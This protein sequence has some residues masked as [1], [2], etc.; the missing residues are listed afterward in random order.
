[1]S[2]PD[3]TYK[4]NGESL[5][6]Q[7]F[8]AK[9]A[10]SPEL[11]EQF[12]R[13][14]G[15]QPLLTPQ[16]QPV[17]LASEPTRALSSPLL[18]AIQNAA[19]ASPT[20]SSDEAFSPK[21]ASRDG[22][23]VT[24]ALNQARAAMA[25]PV[26]RALDGK[27]Q[28]PDFRQD[29][30]D[31][32]SS[33]LDAH[34]GA[35]V[36]IEEAARRVDNRLYNFGMTHSQQIL[37]K[38]MAAKRMQNGWEAITK[39][40]A[41][42]TAD[43]GQ[44]LLSQHYLAESH[45]LM[46]DVSE[47]LTQSAKVT[48]LG[49]VLAKLFNPKALVPIGYKWP[50]TRKQVTAINADAT[51]RSIVKAMD[52]AKDAAVDSTEKRAKGLLRKAAAIVAKKTGADASEVERIINAMG[53]PDISVTEQIEHE[54]VERQIR[55]VL[56]ALDPS[57]DVTP[58]LDT[59]YEQVN[60]QVSEILDKKT[61]PV[62]P[63][64]APK[65]L[66]AD[67]IEA[68][69]ADL[70]QTK[71]MAQAAFDATVDVLRAANPDLAAALEGQ[72][73]DFKIE[74]TSEVKRLSKQLAAIR[75]T[76]AAASTPVTEQVKAAV[77]TSEVK[78]AMKALEKT[79]TPKAALDVLYNDVRRQ[80]AA[81]LNRWLADIGPK[82]GPQSAD[83]RVLA[84]KF[85][86]IW[87][88]SQLAEDAFKRA[89][90]AL[91]VQHPEMKAALS[92]AVFDPN[93]NPESRKIVRQM[94]DF[95]KEIYQTLR[96][97]HATR[98][99]LRAIVRTGMSKIVD[100]T[101][102]DSVA[103]A[104]VSVYDEELV[105]HTN[106]ALRSLATNNQA[107]KEKLDTPTIDKLTKAANLGALAEEQFYNILAPRFGLPAWD[108]DMADKIDLSLEEVQRL[109]E[110]SIQR[111][112]QSMKIMSEI[113]K[114]HRQSAV[115]LERFSHTA[116]VLSMFWTA[117]LLS[118]PVTHIVNGASTAA[119]ILLENMV[120]ATG[121]YWANKSKVGNAEA[122][123]Y[124]GDFGRALANVF[125]GR[126]GAALNSKVGIDMRAALTAGVTRFKSDKG[127][128]MSPLEGW[129]YKTDPKSLNDVF[130]NWLSMYKYVG[131]AMLMA[132]SANS[133]IAA[134]SNLLMRARFEAQESGL[135]GQALEDRLSEVL[136]NSGNAYAEAKKQAQEEYDRGDF[137]QVLPL[138]NGAKPIPA[139][140]M[141]A[142]RI[143]QL[144]EEKLFKADDIQAARD[145]AARATFNADNTGLIGMVADQIG[146]IN[147]KLG[148]TKVIFPFVRTLANLTNNA[149]DY[150]PYG[151]AR[152][153]NF[154][155]AG[156]LASRFHPDSL[157]GREYL[158][159]VPDRIDPSSPEYYAQMTR[160]AAGTATF[161]LLLG[162]AMKGLDDEKDG[163]RAFFEITTS[164]PA[165]FAQRKVLQSSGWLPNSVRI[166]DTRF[167]W[168]DWPA[169]NMV[170][171][172]L[173][174]YSD[175]RRY[176]KLGDKEAGEQLVVAAL[177]V[178]SSIM[179]RSMFT[180]AA[181]LFK[182]VGGG[183]DAIG[184]AKNLTGSAVGGFTNPS[185]L[186]WIRATFD[187]NGLPEQATT[188][189]WLASMTPLAVANNQPAINVLGQPI[190]VFPWEATT[191]RFG[192]IN[193]IIKP[194]P[195]LT[196]LMQ[197]GL[198]L[199]VARR[200]KLTDPK[201]GEKRDMSS[202]EF[203]DYSKAYGQTVAKLVTPKMAQALA[204][205]PTA[206]AQAYLDDNVRKAAR[207]QAGFTIQRSWLK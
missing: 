108:Q 73:L 179:D 104:L 64:E 100:P 92:A 141:M 149:L 71:E 27:V 46:H 206:A 122:L 152:A 10:S 45:A 24:T 103:D 77:V 47:A 37:V 60:K 23:L 164:G 78:R 58:F 59:L 34:V 198:F 79:G 109:P 136:D 148:V 89:V 142:R 14:N 52:D 178:T 1:M 150:T 169:I 110:G 49:N 128:N 117:G 173:G 21:V 140:L 33:F 19:K 17:T 31:A 98:D 119:S 182:A 162:L 192:S 167:V 30:V 158:K 189:G 126:E 43:A 86:D 161:A 177:G 197:A 116:D 20:Q 38:A 107:A 203:Y 68:R 113:A 145:F 13:T 6:F 55:R 56:A 90:A 181:N 62:G 123:K 139:K 195:V 16:D 36:P 114:A 99:R 160:A 134:Q 112:E 157:K 133:M 94:V 144:V 176:N 63:K 61:A 151:F 121:Y 201:T 39:E 75:K 120:T 105:A 204:K 44:I 57:T 153:R 80:A 156:M 95:Q 28:M 118:S 76:Q 135:T 130:N 82:E 127:D 165:D 183:Q 83:P 69:L 101:I 9:V 194:D 188:Y 81:Q 12:V 25:E 205:M 8:R 84:A 143:D 202:Q 4:L 88:R 2:R 67:E 11:M 29:D 74:D 147:S 191:K 146:E 170:L 185:A 18:A 187:P 111:N 171:A 96:D 93:F 26:R 132:D 131:R 115:G 124:Y 129:V 40:I 175:A 54:V 97:K 125:T 184:A 66:T 35:G 193:D 7:Q 196:P 50:I 106:K 87:D 168:S 172:A 199:P 41:A 166:G 138:N 32:A 190:T 3:C 42:G 70:L 186:R 51:G 53:N 65:K 207:D 5:T 15:L 72:G 137:H 174:S 200:T 22:A 159:F 102:A 48:N 163:K 155:L 154:S 85:A 91:E 180:G